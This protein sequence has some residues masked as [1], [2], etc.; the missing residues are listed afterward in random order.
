M[1]PLKDAVRTELTD[2]G[3][4]PAAT[5]LAAVSGGPDSV[6]L[7]HVLA[8]L[9]YRVELAHFDHQTRG[10]ES[11]ADAH[12][13]ETLAKELGAP[14]HLRSED[15]E[16]AAAASPLSFEEYARERR[17]LFLIETALARECHAIATGHHAD[18][19]AETVLMRVLRGTAP[20][21]LGGIPPSTQRDGFAVVRPMIR[22]RR[23][24]ILRY[25]EE[26]GHAFREDMSNF[27]LGFL[28]NRIRHSL[29]PQ[30][31]RE[32]NP[33]LVEALN[34]LADIQRAENALLQTL[35][36]QFERQC[37]R[38]QGTIAREAFAAGHR[39][40]QRRLVLSLAWRYGVEPDFEH[41]ERAIAFIVEAAPVKQFDLGGGIRL[42]AGP[43]SVTLARH[44]PA[45]PEQGEVSL[46]VPGKTEAF[47][48]QLRVSFLQRAPEN[49]AAYC[50][51]RRQV[52]DARALAQH[53][54]VRHRR[55]G[56]RL[57]PLGLGGT[58][59]LKDY[60][61]DLGIPAEARDRKLLIVSGE[62][63]VWVVGHAVSQKA[64]V[65]QSTER[66]AQIEVLDAIE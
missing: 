46:A 43:D 40:L 15:V 45:T 58:R 50:T 16:T 1:P 53:P 33:R 12:F 26:H 36:E 14:F 29:M 30:L 61:S 27:E 31:T 47:G 8:D 24:D 19:Q 6:A 22:V 3:L 48:T 11:A 23:A 63:I 66:V 64:A 59:K 44:E 25:L 54:L 38:G 4:D 18:D 7:A 28:R 56:D 51:P 13:V 5:I 57:A 9:G 20:R 32:Y 10:G 17:Y 39:A 41:V 52:V 37:L 34:R 55:P 35:A 21:G 49:L 2:A 62:E 42:T 65:T 60:L